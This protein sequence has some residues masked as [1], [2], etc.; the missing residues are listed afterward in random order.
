MVEVK[1]NSSSS[2]AIGAV[3]RAAGLRPSAIR[4]YEAAGL[5]PRPPRRSGRR[6]YD[7]SAL[8]RLA[9]IDLAQ[10]AGFTIAET[11]TLLH[12]FGAR[13]APPARWRTLTERKLGEIEARISEAQRMRRVLEALRRCRCP[14]LADCGRAL[15]D[16]RR[17]DT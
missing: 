4:Y 15:R 9:V 8:E 3:A 14:T 1:E 13:T 11:R 2:L 5:L 10:R 17:T 16:A 7:A 12:G 6:V